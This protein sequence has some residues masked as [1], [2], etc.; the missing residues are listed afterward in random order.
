MCR[1]SGGWSCISS[2]WSAM[3]CP[4]M[5]YEARIRRSLF[6]LPTRPQ[7]TSRP[8]CPQASVMRLL[9]RHQGPSDYAPMATNTSSLLLFCLRWDGSKRD[10]ESRREFGNRLLACLPFT[11]LNHVVALVVKNLAANAGDTRCGFNPWVEKIPWRR[12]W[13]LTPAFLPETFHG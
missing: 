11:S 13:H 1:C 5:S 12:V 3:K 8:P 10:S 7:A 2:L 6:W 4:V 9:L